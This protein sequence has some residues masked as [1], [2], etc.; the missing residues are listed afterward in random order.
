M[1]MACVRQLS[2]I[3]QRPEIRRIADHNT[4]HLI[5]YL[6]DQARHVVAALCPDGHTLNAVCATALQVRLSR[7][8]VV[9]VHAGAHHHSLTLGQSARH[10]YGFC[11]SARSIVET[12]VGEGQ[13]V[14]LAAQRLKLK[15]GLQG[16]LGYLRLVRGVGGIKLAT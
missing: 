6:R 1:L 2:Y 16:A 14:K 5:A 11:C 4:R 13:S 9:R 12:G 10:P 15:D 8:A 3:S 7:L